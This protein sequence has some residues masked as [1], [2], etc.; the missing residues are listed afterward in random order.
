MFIVTPTNA[1]ISITKLILNHSD[2]FRCQYTVFR[3]FTV[4]L[5]EVMNY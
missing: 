1:H 2:M 5:A 4:V 3:Q